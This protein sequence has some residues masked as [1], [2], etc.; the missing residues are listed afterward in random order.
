MYEHKFK[1]YSKKIIPHLGCPCEIIKNEQDAMVIAQRYKELLEIGKA[2]GFTPVIIVPIRLV[3][4][5][6]RKHSRRRHRI[7]EKAYTLDFEYF[8]SKRERLLKNPE[9]LLKKVDWHENNDVTAFF[10][11]I[12]DKHKTMKDPS[13]IKICETLIIAKIP[14]ANPWEVAA[15]IPLSYANKSPKPH[16]QVAAFRHWYNHYGAIPAAVNYCEWELYL[17]TPIE[18]EQTAQDIS[19]QIRKFNLIEYMSQDD[20]ADLAIKKRPIWVVQVLH[21]P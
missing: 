16:Q 19:S 18:D 11:S 4:K 10:V 7:L 12:I 3:Y 21:R 17:P 15:W 14:T 5:M 9:P 8:L 13:D 20:F 2:E 1:D 6:I